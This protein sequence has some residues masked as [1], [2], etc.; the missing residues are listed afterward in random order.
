MIELLLFIIAIPLW[1]IWWE[2]VYFRKIYDLYYSK[3]K[4]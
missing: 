3:R 4:P 2:V 1:A